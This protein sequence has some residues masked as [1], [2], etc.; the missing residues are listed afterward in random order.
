MHP[1]GEKRPRRALLRSDWTGRTLA[2]SGRQQ[3]A[4]HQGEHQRAHDGRHRR[5]P[6]RPKHGGLSHLGRHT[7]HR[8][9]RQPARDRHQQDRLHRQ[10]RRR[11]H[12]RVPHGY[13]RPHRVCRPFVLHHL[14]RTSFR[15]HRPARRRAKHPRPGRLRDGAR[16][17]PHDARPAADADVHRFE[18]LLRPTR[19]L[20]H[21]PRSQRR[22]QQA[23][24][25]RTR[26]AVRVRRWARLLEAA[27]RSRHALDA[28]LAL[29]HRRRAERRRFSAL[30]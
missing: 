8:L 14:A 10:L 30:H 7:Q 20:G 24:P 26:G 18:G 12:D 3:K 29:E 13:R 21:L 19:L 17:L 2:T 6:R 9:S 23:R 28:P 5:A 15:H 25:R 27:P 16:R 1:H 22:L 11:H 4:R